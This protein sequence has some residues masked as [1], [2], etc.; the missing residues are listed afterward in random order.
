MHLMYVTAEDKAGPN[1]LV[2]RPAH[3]AAWSINE[4]KLE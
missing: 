1:P 4:I 2:M 3:L